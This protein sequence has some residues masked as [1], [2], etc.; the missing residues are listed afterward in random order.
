MHLSAQ[1]KRLDSWTCMFCVIGYSQAF[2]GE[3]ITSV[4]IGRVR[5]STLEPC[6]VTL[7]LIEICKQVEG[8]QQHILPV[9]AETV[10]IIKI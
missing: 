7:S 6:H 1:E 9:M 5:K 3:E 8:E 2:R 4:K 10:S